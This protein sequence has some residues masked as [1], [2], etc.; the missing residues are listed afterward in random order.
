MTYT[1]P[2]ITKKLE[3]MVIISIIILAPFWPRFLT[4]IQGTRKIEKV[5]THETTR[6]SKKTKL[7]ETN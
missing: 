5:E 3:D 1:K 7:I 6:A 4:W 2:E